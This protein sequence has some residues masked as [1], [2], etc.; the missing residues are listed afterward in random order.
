MTIEEKKFL[1]YFGDLSDL[2]DCRS[3]LL[4]NSYT[5]KFSIGDIPVLPSKEQPSLLFLVDGHIRHIVSFDPDI[6]SRT[7]A[8]YAYP[9]VLGVDSL[10]F[11][12]KSNHDLLCSSNCVFRVLPL[13]SFLLLKSSYIT[14]YLRFLSTTQPLEAWELFQSSKANFND[15]PF[16]QIKRHYNQLLASLSASCPADSDELHQLSANNSTLYLGQS[17]LTF[18]YGYQLTDNDLKELR[19]PSRILYSSD[20]TVDNLVSENALSPQSSYSSQS[21]THTIGSKPSDTTSIGTSNSNLDQ[22][23]HQNISNTLGSRIKHYP[24]PKDSTSIVTSCFRSL[25]YYFNLPI[26]P[27][28]IRQILVEKYP[29]SDEDVSLELCAALAESL[30]L[31]TQLLSLPINLLPRLQVP[32]FIRIS[33]SEICVALENKSGSITIC[34]PSQGLTVFN[35]SLS[36]QPFPTDSDLSVLIFRKTDFTPEKKFGLSWFIPSLKRHKRSLIEVF[37][38]S[39]FVQ[40]F[41]LM[42]PLIVQQIIDKV[43]GQGGTGTLPVLAFMIFIFALFE[44]ILTAL[45]TNLF[46]E[47]TNRIDISLGEQVIDHLL[48]LPLSYFDKRPVGELSSRL[49]EL[50]TI[51]SFLTGTALTVVLDVVFSIIYIAVMLLYSWVLTIVALLVAPILGL[52]TYSLSP[53]IRVQLRNKAE[54]NAHTQNHLVEVLTGIQT[55]KAQNFETNARWRWK[56]RYSKYISKSFTNAVT[57]TTSNALTQFLNQASNLLVLCVGTFLVVQGQLS[58][59]QLIAFRII[60]GYVTTPLLRLSNLYQSFQQTSISLER[61][62]DIID[63]VPEST[64]ADQKNIPMPHIHG[65]ISYRD[66]SFGFKPNTPLQI[67][68]VSLDIP[69]GQFVAIVGQSGSGK[70]TLTK[71]LPRLYNPVAGRILVDDI[72]ISKVELYSLRSQIGIVPQDSML[73]D[74]TVQD[75]ISLSDPDASV[76]DVIRAAKLA[77]AHDFI[78]SLPSG[79]ATP[80]GERG[81]ALSG[82][83]RQRIAIARSILQ[84]PRLLIMDEAT[85]ALDY[86]TERAVSLNLMD[87][88]RGKTVLFITH[89]LNSIIHADNIILMHEGRVDETGTHSELMTMRGRY[90]ALFNQQDSD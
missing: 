39:F 25:A 8:K 18:D 72:D 56:D 35:T 36:N 47:T 85:S 70:S 80:V 21:T 37:V 60:A 90:Y 58:L 67:S 29:D 19:F 45:R 5:L 28:S 23:S 46:I 14:I 86:E 10:V 89:R 53:V 7:L 76:D 12:S 83:Q 64:M 50:E 81:G 52:I 42:N 74:G 16:S 32:A 55:V 31:Q 43:I 44:N 9:C 79:Y 24:S 13:S 48:R 78:M 2:D 63:T 30:G 77:C 27:D 17:Q 69:A 65:S 3:L 33:S 4:D 71:L 82:G 66:V 57:S 62:A 6:G 61:L 38:A 51:R 54:L 75:N 1:E 84:N 41:Q 73:F 15:I 34:R 22:S 20:P 87:H 40:L 11:G 59:G 88:F 49:S 68:N 26:K